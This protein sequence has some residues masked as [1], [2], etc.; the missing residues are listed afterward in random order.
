MKKLT[1]LLPIVLGLLAATSYAGQPMISS[2]KETKEYKQVPEETCFNDREFQIDLFGQYT[3]GE[4]PTH[5][6]PMR[7]HG[8]GGGIGLNYFFLRNVGIGV[9]AAWLDM[10]ENAAFARHGSNDGNTALHAFSGSLILRLP[11]DHLCL[12]PYVYAGGGFQVDGAQW[13]SAHAG[14]GLEYRIKPHK[15]GFFVDG[16]WT[17]FGDREGYGDLNNFTARAGFR[18]VF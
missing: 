17:Y 5:A 18:I 7:D 6:G 8:W 12:A 10:K 11:I 3:V 1:A 2:G 4:G 14:A 16:R 13:A 9:D 15:L